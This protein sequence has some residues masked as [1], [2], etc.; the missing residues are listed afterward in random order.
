MNATY[1]IIRADASIQMGT[2][3][4]MRCLALGQAWQDR[5]GKVIFITACKS[6]TLQR[7]LLDEGFQVISL[8]GSYP[9]PCDWE[10]T[11]QIL[12]EHPGAW[13]ALDGYHFDS[14]YQHGIKQANHPL[15]VIDDMAHLDHYYA[16]IVLNQNLYSENLQYSCE[17][18]TH[19]LLGTKYVLLRREFRRWQGW[20]RSVPEMAHKVLVTL[21]GSDP[22]N[23]TLKVIRSLQHLDID[24]IEVVAVVGGNNPHQTDLQSVAQYSHIPVHIEHNVSDMASIMAWADIAISAGGSTVWELAFMEL[25]S[26]VLAIADN[27]RLVVAEIDKAGVAVNLG[28]HSDAS[29][30]TIAQRTR[31][32]MRDAEARSEMVLRGRRLIDGAGSKRV[33]SKMIGLPILHVRRALPTDVEILY[34]WA[35]D[36]L[37]RTMSFHSNVISWS[38]HQRWFEQVLTSSDT[39]LM[40][41]ELEENN[42]R[43]PVGQVRV[44]GRGTVSISIAPQYRGRHLGAYLLKTALDYYFRSFQHCPLT[45]YIKPE[46]QASQKIFSQVGFRLVGSVE[47]K[48]QSALK[49]VY[50]P[51]NIFNP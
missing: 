12:A 16:D 49:Y 41:G 5:G 1:L 36:Q 30:V 18:Y 35:N 7:R 32:I 45:A 28:W 15:L 19:L 9:D 47:I 51:S 42:E 39:L 20:Q 10:Y 44:D 50:Y 13:V 27:Q 8:E 14:T 4:L 40:I 2:G 48:G 29:A 21:G 22:E 26:L 38:E 11:S 34:S 17:P 25:P 37:T 24:G 33:I 6:N 46:N 23:V 3:H 31:Q 43:I